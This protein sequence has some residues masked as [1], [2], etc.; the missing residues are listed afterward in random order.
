MKAFCSIF[1][2]ERYSI[3]HEGNFLILEKLSSHFDRKDQEF[4]I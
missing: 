4:S 3:I 2:S 1:V